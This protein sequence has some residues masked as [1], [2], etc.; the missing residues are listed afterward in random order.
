MLS[1]CVAASRRVLHRGE[2]SSELLPPLGY[3]FMIDAAVPNNL[4]VAALAPDRVPQ[5]G[6]YVPSFGDIATLR[7]SIL[8][9]R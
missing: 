8:G 5:Q 1:L 4:T 3:R 2:I 9:I 7:G 6:Q